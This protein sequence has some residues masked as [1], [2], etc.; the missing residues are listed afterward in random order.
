MEMSHTLLAIQMNT[1]YTMRYS[2]D[3]QNSDGSVRVFIQHTLDILNCVCKGTISCTTNNKLIQ[4]MI[5]LY[6]IIYIH[7]DI[8]MKIQHD[9]PWDTVCEKV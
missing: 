5:R 8:S 4:L 7:E 6:D 1:K 2:D 3:L 9:R